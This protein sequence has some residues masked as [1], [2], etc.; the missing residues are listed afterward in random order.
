MRGK[1]FYF[2]SLKD[3]FITKFKETEEK[4][5]GIV[6]PRHIIYKEPKIEIYKMMQQIWNE[7]KRVS[8]YGK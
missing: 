3:D 7:Y 5:G 8:N 4:L 6:Y 1:S 2:Y